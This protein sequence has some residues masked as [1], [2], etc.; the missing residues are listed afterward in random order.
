MSITLFALNIPCLSKSSAHRNPLYVFPT[1]ERPSSNNLNA[2]NCC[3][4]FASI[5]MYL[6]IWL[7]KWTKELIKSL[8]LHRQYSRNRYI[9][10]PREHLECLNHQT[11]SSSVL[12][13]LKRM[14]IWTDRFEKR[15]KLKQIVSLLHCTTE[16]L[17]FGNH[18]NSFHNQIRL[19]KK[20]HHFLPQKFLHQ[21][22]HLSIRPCS[23]HRCLRSLNVRAN[24]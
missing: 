18:K 9:T 15:Q 24:N 13:P 8:N 19:W 16:L 10:L 21:I 7:L 22:K 23:K 12:F 3:L 6:K 2:E 11:R 14:W 20:M 5:Y 4:F 1:P 17:R